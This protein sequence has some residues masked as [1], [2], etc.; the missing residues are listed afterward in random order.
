MPLTDEQ[1][2]LLDWLDEQES[3]IVPVKDIQEKFP[4]AEWSVTGVTMTLDDEGNSLIPK[5]DVRD[6]ILRGEARD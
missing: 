4:D 2:E 1:K 3:Y 5:K 6:G